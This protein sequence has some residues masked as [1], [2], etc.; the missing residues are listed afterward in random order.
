VADHAEPLVSQHAH[1]LDLVAGE[2]AHAV[3]RVVRRARW[4]AAVAE[5]AEVGGDHGEALGEPRR[6]P[7]PHEMRLG[8]A[9]QQQDRRTVAAPAPVDR[10]TGGGDVER[11]ETIEHGVDP[12]G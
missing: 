1:D 10:R 11:F 6:H 7:M 8:D 2:L 12:F 9:V 3:R 5:A 4:R